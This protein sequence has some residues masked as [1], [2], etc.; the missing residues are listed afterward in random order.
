MP[1]RGG[2]RDATECLAHVSREES[3]GREGAAT[4]SVV[5]SS[6]IERGQI[7]ISGL[8]PQPSTDARRRSQVIQG[9][10]LD[11]LETS[12]SVE[13]FGRKVI[14]KVEAPEHVR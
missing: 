9:A 2:K 12:K 5:A 8:T 13:A 6:G 1:G 11:A 14:Q 10:A 3:R 7:R 4:P